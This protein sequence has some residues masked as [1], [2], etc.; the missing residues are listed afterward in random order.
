M[1]KSHQGLTQLLGSG[2]FDIRGEVSLGLAV[3]NPLLTT[4]VPDIS[5]GP[6]P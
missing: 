4:P 3:A 5:V 2:Q 1:V 6:G